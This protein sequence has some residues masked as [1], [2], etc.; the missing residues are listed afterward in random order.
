ME[1]QSE[2]CGLSKSYRV[3]VGSGHV[4]GYIIHIEGIGLPHLNTIL[5]V[6]CTTSVQL[7]IVNPPGGVRI[8]ANPNPNP[9]VVE[10]MDRA[11]GPTQDFFSQ[12]L[13]GTL[14]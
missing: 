14:A 6:N 7:K 9:L 3:E 12:N 4:Y 8:H 5:D 1:C 11:H 13:R 10:Y 2:S